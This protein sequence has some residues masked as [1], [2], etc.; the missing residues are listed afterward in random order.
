LDT[1]LKGFKAARPEMFRKLRSLTVNDFYYGQV[2]KSGGTD[3]EPSI[4]LSFGLPT[5]TSPYDSLMRY[6]N[7]L[8]LPWGR[9]WQKELARMMKEIK[10]GDVL[11]VEVK[12]YDPET[13]LAVLE[14][15]KRPRVNGGLIVLDKGEVRAAISGFD[16]K[17]FNRAVAAKR[18]P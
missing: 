5:G 10:V 17:G 12:E 18:Q 11:Y 2:T 1:I 9:G 4:E 6:A 8:D 13:H 15:N 3:K 7:G 16:T 14:M